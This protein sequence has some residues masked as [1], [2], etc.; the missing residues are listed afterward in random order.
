MKNSYKKNISCFLFS[1]SVSL[2]GSSLVEFALIWHITLTT[3]SGV[4]MT[5]ATLCTFAPRLIVSFFAGVIIDKYNRKSLIILS[6]SFVAFVTLILAICYIN[7]IQS[8]NLIFLVLSLRSIGT[9]IQTPAI[10]SFITQIVKKEDLLRVNGL[11]N[12]LQSLITLLAP[13]MSGA[14]LSTISLSLIFFIDVFTAIFGILILYYVKS[15]PYKV[16]NSNNRYL[17]DLKDGIN[18]VKK[19]HIVKKMLYILSIYYLLIT[20]AALLCQLIITRNFGDEVWRLTVNEVCF[21]VGSI[22][23]GVLIHQIAKKFREHTILCLSCISVGLLNIALGFSNFL[24]FLSIMFLLGVFMSLFSSIQISIIQRN[25]NAN[26]QGRVFG[27][28]Q[29]VVNAGIPIGMIIFGPLGDYIS[30]QYIFSFAGV[31]LCILGYFSR[32]FKGI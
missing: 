4:M 16:S 25:V 13:A 14:I 11:N 22:I 12:S 5:I 3:K 8:L 29:I 7:G 17:S 24:I 19:N 20:P 15:E 28:I 9:G 23:G 30:L 10:N 27:F 26:M 1:Q 31:G 21:S 32:N 6:D 18:Y 2:F